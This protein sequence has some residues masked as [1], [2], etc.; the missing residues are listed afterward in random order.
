MPYPLGSLRYAVGPNMMN[1]PFD[2]N[3]VRFWLARWSLPQGWSFV[4]EGILFDWRLRQAIFNFQRKIMNM[5][6]PS[7]VISPGDAT[8]RRL[9]AGPKVHTSLSIPRRPPAG[10]LALNPSPDTPMMLPKRTGYQAI[11]P[12]QF[13]AAADTLGCELA[14]IQ[15]VGDVEGKGHGFDEYDRPVIL[16]EPTMFRDLAKDKSYAFKYPDLTHKR[17]KPLTAYGPNNLQ[18]E[19]LQ[20]AYLLD[21]QAALLS[22]SWGRFQ[23]LGKS[24]PA[25]GFAS[26]AAMVSTLCRSEQAQLSAFLEY[27]KQRHLA[28]A[29]AARDWKIVAAGYN[30]PNYQDYD[31]DG[32]MARAYAKFAQ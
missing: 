3:T 21:P 14:A 18:W 19:H 29:L 11:T 27:I 32:K 15:A 7:G 6:F 8:E 4:S 1:S 12:D 30:G 2:L 24:F 23:A 25:H 9:A 20:R 5:G 16:F 28:K 13:K 26:P 31:Y 17:L 10:P 22:T